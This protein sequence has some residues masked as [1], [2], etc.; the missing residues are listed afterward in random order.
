MS[1]L[2]VPETEEGSNPSKGKRVL[3]PLKFFSPYEVPAIARHGRGEVIGGC[4]LNGCIKEE[5]F[6]CGLAENFQSHC[7][8]YKAHRYFIGCRYRSAAGFC[9]NQ[10]AVEEAR[11]MKNSGGDANESVNKCDN[12]F[13][14]L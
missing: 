10:K 13:I 4:I 12:Y 6:L 1:R 5:C 8:Y 9:A 3:N 11:K 7:L 14:A 2:D